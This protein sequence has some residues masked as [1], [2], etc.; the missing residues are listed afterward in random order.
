VF[1]DIHGCYD[2]FKLL[3]D[4]LSIDKEDKLI[5]LGDYIDRG[6]KSYQIIDF[7]INL[8]ENHSNSIF[9]TGNH[10][11]MLLDFIDHPN[12]V[13][14][15]NIYI[16]N[17][18]IE[19]L[20]SYNIFRYYDEISDTFKISGDLP[21]KHLTFIRSLQLYYETDNFIFVHAGI[22]PYIK[23]WKS[24]ETDMT[25]IRDPFL[26]YSKNKLPKIVIHGHTP[27]REVNIHLPHK[28]KINIDTGAFHYGK[29]TCAVLP[30]GD[31]TTLEDLKFI[32]KIGE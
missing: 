17:G 26:T 8:K 13:D 1:T 4:S 30:Y 9:L 32:S 19:T 27:V 3:F 7:L 21:H 15:R 20:D 11:Q 23:D 6:N 24:H 18:G 31:N 29:L 10:E 2:L 25:W 16:N 12:N 28:D 5:F 14:Y 22:N